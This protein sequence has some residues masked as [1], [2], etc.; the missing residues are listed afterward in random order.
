[1]LAVPVDFQPSF[2]LLSV[3]ELQIGQTLVNICSRFL[4]LQH[5]SFVFQTSLTFF[6]QSL[7]KK[8]YYPVNI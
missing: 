5:Q 8:C 2:C 4:F 3:A 1:M 7:N 6:L